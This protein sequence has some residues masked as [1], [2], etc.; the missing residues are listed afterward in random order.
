MDYKIDLL[1]SAV[2]D[3]DIALDWYISKNHELAE[4]FYEVYFTVE[5]RIRF[6][7]TIW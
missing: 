3:L 7:V 4:R 6:I 1:E 5:D 2:E